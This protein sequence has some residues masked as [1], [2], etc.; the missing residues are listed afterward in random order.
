M[1]IGGS[2]DTDYTSARCTMQR[3][4]QSSLFELVTSLTSWFI[5]GKIFLNAMLVATRLKA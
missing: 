2:F 4:Y 3:E 1:G 5:K